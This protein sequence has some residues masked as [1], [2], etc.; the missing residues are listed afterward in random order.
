M[1]S[2]KPIQESGPPAGM[3]SPSG[4]QSL[5]SLEHLNEIQSLYDLTNL[6][7]YGQAPINSE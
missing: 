7:T 4:G 3:T 6:D 1:R 2:K 5:D